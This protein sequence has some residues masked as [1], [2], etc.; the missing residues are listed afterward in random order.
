ME[1]YVT[2]DQL[3]N[4]VLS[5]L[6]PLKKKIYLGQPTWFNTDGNAIFRISKQK[7]FGID[8]DIY[9]NIQGLLNITNDK[10]DSMLWDVIDKLGETL[11]GEPIEDAYMY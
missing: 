7:S 4:V 6:G 5:Y 3:V 9:Y 8:Q 1:Y 10:D 2:V 11:T